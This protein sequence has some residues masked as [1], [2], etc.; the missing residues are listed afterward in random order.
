MPSNCVVYSLL[1][2]TSVSAKKEGA[3]RNTLQDLSRCLDNLSEMQ[4]SG[5]R[6]EMGGLDEGEGGRG[7]GCFLIGGNFWHSILVQPQHSVWDF[8]FRQINWSPI[9]IFKLLLLFSSKSSIEAYLHLWWRYQT[10]MPGSKMQTQWVYYC[11]ICVCVFYI[12][13]FIG[14]LNPWAAK[15]LGR[16]LSFWQLSFIFMYTIII[17]CIVWLFSARE[18]QNT[19]WMDEWMLFL[20]FL[21]PWQGPATYLL[22]GISGE[23]FL[24]SHFQGAFQWASTG[25]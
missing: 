7:G 22:F 4:K 20:C 18:T 8:L 6:S 16:W 9:I 11:A 14:Q 21:F 13:H 2:P 25:M 23:L 3:K 17:V 1:W 10:E 12:R 15:S 19:F 5:K 24:I